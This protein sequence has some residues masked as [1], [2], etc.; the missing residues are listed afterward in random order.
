RRWS[1][2][3]NGNTLD[4]TLRIVN[5]IGTVTHPIRRFNPPF[6]RENDTT[7]FGS[8]GD[9]FQRAPEIRSRRRF[10]VEFDVA[11]NRRLDSRVVMRTNTE[12]DVKRFLQNKT[13]RAS[14]RSEL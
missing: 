1:A 2:A 13:K 6:G 9:G 8:D 12:P 7:I 5:Q 14:R 4:A 10:V 3:A 11:E